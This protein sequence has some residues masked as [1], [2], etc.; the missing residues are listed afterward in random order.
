M[1]LCSPASCISSA[2][3]YMHI[4][5]MTGH[6]P[7]ANGAGNCLFP[8][9]LC[10]CLQTDGPEQFPSSLPGQT[11]GTHQSTRWGL[12]WR[13]C[14]ASQLYRNPLLLLLPLFTQYPLCNDNCTHRRNLLWYYFILFYTCTLYLVC[15]YIVYQWAIILFLTELLDPQCSEFDYSGIFFTEPNDPS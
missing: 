5:L 11:T 10:Q 7:P 8:E 4:T 3:L 14:V 2:F 12:L 9:G 13:H 6:H 1:S 15:L